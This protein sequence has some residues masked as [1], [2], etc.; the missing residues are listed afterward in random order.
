MHTARHLLRIACVIIIAIAAIA[1]P[2]TAK[3]ATVHPELQDKHLVLTF[4]SVTD[5]EKDRWYVMYNVG[6]K[7]FLCDDELK[8]H[9]STA[10][11]GPDAMKYLVR[12]TDVKGYQVLETG[13]GRYF[14][15]LST[16][17]NGGTTTSASSSN[18]FSYGK[19]EDGYFWFKDKNGMVLDANALSSALDA[20]ATVAGWGKDTPTSTTGNNSWRLFPVE[21]IDGSDEMADVPYSFGSFSIQSVDKGGYLYLDA[22]NLNLNVDEEKMGS[23]LINV[24]GTWSLGVAEGTGQKT[25]IHIGTGGKFSAGPASPLRLYHVTETDGGYTYSEAYSVVDGGTY[26]IV[27]DYEDKTYALA[28]EITKGGTADQRMLSSQVALA[29]DLDLDASGTV[30][31]ATF[32]GTYADAP[33]RHHWQFHYGESLV[34]PPFVYTTGETGGASGSGEPLLTIAC[35][36]DIH[37]QEGWLTKTSWAD[38]DNGYY[39][40]Q[41][42]K[43]VRVR[44]SLAEA[45]KALQGEKVDVLIVGGD[46][47]SDATVD[48]EH[49]RQVRRL[50]ADALRSVNK[51]AKG[52]VDDDLPVLY[53]NGN[54]EYEVASTWGGNGKGYYNWRHTRPFNAGEYYEFPMAGDVGTLAADYDC[55]YEN[56]P[57]DAALG[58]KKT[59]PVLGAYH[60]NIKGFDFVVLNCGKHLFHNA[61]NYTYSEESVEWVAKKLQHIYAND[62]SGQKTVFF[63]LHIPFGDSNSVNTNEDKGMTYEPSTHRLKEILAQYPG[64]VM[65]YGH[66]HGQDLA[67]IRSKTSQ[68][69]TRYDRNGHVMATADGVTTYD[70]DVTTG[71]PFKAT[72]HKGQNVAFHPYS[73]SQTKTLGVKGSYLAG[74][75]QVQRSLAL[76]DT[77][78]TCRVLPEANGAV[79]LRFGDG[80]Q[81]LTYSSNFGLTAAEHQPLFLY[82]VDIDG[83]QFKAT[84]V[85][86]VEN[87]ATYMIG[88]ATHVYRV[89]GQKAIAEADS[90]SVS[91]YNTFFWTADVDQ[92]ADPGFVSSFMGSCRYYANSNG[93]PAN[94]SYGNRKLIQGLIIY[95]YEDR[96]VFNM[97]NFRNEVRSRVRNELSPYV[98]LRSTSAAAPAEQVAHNASGAYYRRVDDLSQLCDRSVCILVDESRKRSIGAA[99][100]TTGKLQALEVNP[101]D[102]R[103]EVTRN[104]TESEMVFEKKP[105]G[106]ALLPNDTQHW[107]LRTHDGY[108]KSDETKVFYRQQSVNYLT[109]N[110]LCNEALKGTIVPWTITLDAEGIATISNA[111]V[112]DLRK[113]TNGMTT[114][115]LA[116]YQKVVA[117]DVDPATGLATFYAE[118][119]IS[120]S[121]GAEA[122]TVEGVGDNGE[123]QFVRQPKTVPAKT[124]LVLRCA[125]THSGAVEFRVIDD[126]YAVPFDNM[127]AGTLAN[128][129]TT[130]PMGASPDE[131]Y[132]FYRFDGRTFDASAGGRAFVNTAGEAYLALPRALAAL[133]D[134]AATHDV[135]TLLDKATVNGITNVALMPSDSHDIFTLSGQRVVKPTQKGVYIMGG[136]KIIVK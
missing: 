62:P 129:E 125:A 74:S 113:Q 4:P 117:A 57:N 36:S 50:M 82:R 75:A 5:I 100:V 37:T 9:I 118:P 27:G 20:T 63:A 108:M 18:S 28:D 10:P 95:V 86:E 77:R 2:P 25:H 116:I 21:L 52:T 12:I 91:G 130:A 39:T 121:V 126:R 115:R 92:E 72:V 133:Y 109:S 1:L 31:G 58:T 64:L 119:A 35:V 23:V 79:S 71:D 3:A 30:L 41:A 13:I 11:P 102:G 66:D 22:N 110:P 111:E 99:D 84:R 42:I 17:N 89:G 44:E 96:I 90:Y 29:P 8:L 80:S 81:H 101:V 65:L 87:G 47:Q 104:T 34:Q 59:M 114:A 32:A 73:S 127:L 136:K 43:D 131:T 98:M 14:K 33:Q 6:R 69:V 56:A 120:T 26:L 85:Q 24:D 46:C 135:S 78:S 19:I 53:V 70:K 67:Y 16:S 97:K 88:S 123:L 128:V 38:K 54:H 124:A 48:E 93:E 15:Y 94:S 45:V 103:I 112:G 106:A 49:W 105:E 132:A 76:L 40:P 7:G 122:Y 68:R 60:Y 107:Y 134:G 51:T 55:F 83:D 61:N